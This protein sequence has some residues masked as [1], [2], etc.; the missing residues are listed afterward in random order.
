MEYVAMNHLLCFGF[1]FSARALAARL[2]PPSN[3]KAW[4]ITG[5]STSEAGCVRIRQAGHEAVLFDGTAPSADVAAALATATHVVVSAPPGEQGDPVLR[6]HSDD[7]RN[8]AQ[9][10]WIGY[11][12]TVGVYG[13]HGGAW[14]DES[15]P[16]KP[17]SPRSQRR[18]AAELAWLAL[19]TGPKPLIGVFRLSGIYGPG[20]SAIDNLRDGSAR[21]IVK[22]G[23]VFNR[24]H[25][26]DIALVLEAAMAR[27]QTSQIY[28]VTDDEPA[29]PQDVVAFAAGLLGLPT[30]PELPFATAAL[31][32]MARSFYSENKRVRNARV[33]QELGVTLAHPT[34]REGMTAI[35]GG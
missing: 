9:L 29:P 10:H 19:P 33:K 18:L 12:S 11:L 32:P 25:V 8:A 7:L 27:Q 28:N 20:R 1:G 14:V 21:R 6:H 35:A 23:Q 26:D 17:G 3:Q 2:S 4:Q 30:P 22:P 5:T 24:I 15:T 16:A 13:D 31:S 34:Y